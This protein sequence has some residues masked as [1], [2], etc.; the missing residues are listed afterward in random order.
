MSLEPRIVVHEQP[1]PRVYSYY[2]NTVVTDVKYH[3]EIAELEEHLFDRKVSDS[4]Q[5]FINQLY[6]VNG[7]ESVMLDRHE[8]HVTKGVAFDWEDIHPRLLDLIKQHCWGD[9]E[10]EVRGYASTGQRGLIE[11]EFGGLTRH[12]E[13]KP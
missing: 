10:V 2:V 3:G 9:R 6:E 8:V 5:E 1:N 11:N 7:V 12:S 4:V 13:E